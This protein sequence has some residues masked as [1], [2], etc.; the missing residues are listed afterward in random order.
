MITVH[1][2]INDNKLK[3][4]T[5]EG[6][7]YY[8]YYYYYHYYYYYWFQTALWM[9]GDWRE[10]PRSNIKLQE[11]LG[12]GAFGEVYKGLVQ[13]D[14]EVIPCAVKKLKGNSFGSIENHYL[15]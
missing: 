5:N 11:K 3:I 1:V 14:G 12:E 4:N 2:T 10:F 13:T 9:R 8:Y 6:N 15:L 7:Y